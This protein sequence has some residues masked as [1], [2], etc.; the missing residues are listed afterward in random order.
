MNHH[1]GRLVHHRQVRV[2]MHHIQRN[3]L[4][5]GPERRRTRLA[6]HRDPLA[7]AQF[8]GSLLAY[9]VHQHA[10]L[11]QEQLHPR[12]AHAVELRRQ[13]LV[14]PLPARLFARRKRP[15]LAHARPSPSAGSATGS[16]CP[17][18]STSFCRKGGRARPFRSRNTTA[19]T[20]TITTPAIC[21][22]SSAPCKTA[23]RPSGSRQ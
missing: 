15:H 1:P 8:E 21:G 6:R 13:K 16:P 4:R 5:R 3:R 2:L 22:P 20:S 7:S 17:V 23:P 10:A 14:E 11:R 18:L 19:P 12:P 9:P